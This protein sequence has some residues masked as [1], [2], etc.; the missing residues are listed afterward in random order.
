[1]VQYNSIRLRLLFKKIYSS[2][3][4]KQ[5]LDTKSPIQYT[6]MLITTRSILKSCGYEMIWLTFQLYYQ[7]FPYFS[8]VCRIRSYNPVSSLSTSAFFLH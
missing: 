2:S 4:T 3:H 5:S 6:V 8:R 7:S 1:M